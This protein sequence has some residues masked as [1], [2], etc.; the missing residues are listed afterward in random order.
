M[1][2]NTGFKRVGTVT[3]STSIEYAGDVAGQ[4][5]R[6]WSLGQWVE[7]DRVT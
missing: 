4:A 1:D 3:L 2:T 5:V 7:N 6:P